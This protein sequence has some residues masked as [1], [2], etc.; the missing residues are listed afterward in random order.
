MQDFDECV[1]FSKV[2]RLSSGKN[3]WSNV[4]SPVKY[5]LSTR[6]SQCLIII[7]ALQFS[8]LFADKWISNANQGK[9]GKLW[10]SPNSIS[11]AK[12]WKKHGIAQVY[13]ELGEEMTLSKSFSRTYTHQR[14][15]S[16]N[17]KAA[18]NTLKTILYAKKACV[19]VNSRGQIASCCNR[20]VVIT[21]FVR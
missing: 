17:M 8:S 9:R 18:D 15:N 3:W 12:H 19:E 7:S 1:P 14:T 20:T 21:T 4:F 2:I 10:K 16:A 6:K 11:S 5:S 13:R